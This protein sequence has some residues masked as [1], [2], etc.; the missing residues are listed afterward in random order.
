MYTVNSEINAMF[1]LR[2]ESQ[3]LYNV[4]HI[5]NLTSHVTVQN[6]GRRNNLTRIIASIGRFSIIN[7][8]NNF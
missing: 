5:S 3:K 6:L 1:L 2:H 7:A 4:T 8:H